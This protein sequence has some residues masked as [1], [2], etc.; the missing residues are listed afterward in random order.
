VNKYIRED[1]KVAVLYSP[2]FGAGWSTWNC[3][4]E[5][6][7]FDK[8][9]V[10][11]VLAKE[12]DYESKISNYLMSAGYGTT[13]LGG[14]DTL[15]VCWLEPGTEFLISEYGGSEGVKVK[16]ELNWNIA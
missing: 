15:S 5:F 4:E 6:L 1:G 2:G 11:I 8:T 14:I 7:I 10:E 16:D 13:Y 3:D 9:L 12:H